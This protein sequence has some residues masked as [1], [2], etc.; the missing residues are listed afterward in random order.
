MKTKLVL[1][2]SA[3]IFTTVIYLHHHH[4]PPADGMCPLAKALAL[5]HE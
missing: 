1:A 4:Q 3:F 2:A 5:T